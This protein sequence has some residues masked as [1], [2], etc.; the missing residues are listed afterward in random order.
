MAEKELK[1]RQSQNEFIAK[2]QRCMNAYDEADKLY[3]EIE[4]FIRNIMPNE[5]SKYDSEQQDYL[6]ILEDYELSDSQLINIGRRLEEN[7]SERKNW[8]NI[9]TI[10]ST[11]NE[12][13]NKIFNRNSRIF[14]RE[15][16]CKAI[17]NLDCKWNFRVLSEDQIETLLTP[18]GNKKVEG[19]KRG[20]KS[21]L[22]EGTL[23]YILK[24]HK[25]GVKTKDIAEELNMKLN[26]VYCLINRNKDKVV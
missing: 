2:L 5:T 9:F 3:D 15:N 21:T 12:H 19:K 23:E 10:S 13:K 16:I 14:L 1:N 8:H 26:T 7:R 25:N 4:D 6:H 11:W 22:P 18:K 20:R 17:K 24:Q